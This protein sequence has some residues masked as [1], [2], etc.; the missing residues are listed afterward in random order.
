MSFFNNYPYTDF[1]ELNLDWVLKNLK[2]LDKEWDEFKVLNTITIQGTWDISKNYP[3]Y[4]IV[5]DNGTG[6]LS[7]K[8]IPAGILISNLDYW[9]PVGTYSTA[10][11]D[12]NSR[13]TTAEGNISSLQGTVAGHTTA[14]NQL[15]PLK[16]V[17]DYLSGT[18]ICIGDSYLQGY[19]PDGNTTPWGTW[20][21]DWLGKSGEYFAYAAGGA[22][23]VHPGQGNKRFEELLQ[24]AIANGAI[25]KNNVSL[26]IFGGGYNDAANNASASDIYDRVRACRLLI[27]ANY[28]NAKPVIAFLGNA[29]PPSICTYDLL[30]RTINRYGNAAA[31]NGFAYI[32]N[33]GQTLKGALTQTLGS[34]GVHPTDGGQQQ[35]AMAILNG[36]GVGDGYIGLNPNFNYAQSNEIFAISDDSSVTINFYIN[37]DYNLTPADFTCNGATEALDI[38]L[39]DLYIRPLMGTVFMVFRLECMLQDSNNLFY[40]VNCYARMRADGH[41]KIF[42][43]EISADHTGYLT[44]QGLK[45]ITILPQMITFPRVLA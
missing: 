30:Y 32:G 8:P 24:D 27:K 38:D 28:P 3:K 7:I 42:P 9:L 18:I 11:A 5:E 12:L 33:A 4:S 34:D 2:E 15:N 22:G 21:R 29:Q 14:I 19:N 44:I 25:S 43:H 6:Y 23:F 1:H 36:I 17:Y 37:H 40:K 35:L 31:S 45:K 39:S 10:I 16:E 13:L 41:L 26:I 20:L